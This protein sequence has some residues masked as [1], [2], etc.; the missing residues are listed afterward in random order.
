[1]GFFNAM[2]SINR[3]NKLLKDL[4]NQVTITQDLV[5]SNA[6]RWQLE[7]SLEVLKRVHQ[8]LINTFSNSAGARV[9]VFTL[10]GDKMRM[11]E[12]L[13]YSKNLIYNLNAVI[14]TR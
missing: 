6:T 12:V 13:T 11:D 5:Q 9:S 8:D 2:T 3:I 7:N 14:K 10:F 1:M 4:E